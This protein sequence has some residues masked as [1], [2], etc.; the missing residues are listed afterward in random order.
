MAVLASSDGMMRQIVQTLYPREK[1][2]ADISP[3]CEDVGHP[4]MYSS[5]RSKKAWSAVYG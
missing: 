2:N 1:Y 3:P 5:N 4:R